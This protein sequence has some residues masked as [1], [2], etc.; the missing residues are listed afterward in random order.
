[1]PRHKVAEKILTKEYLIK[2]YTDDRLTPNQ[3]G[4]IVGCNNSV[5]RRLLKKFG[6][7]IRG[8]SESHKGHTSWNTGLTKETD[9]R[10]AKSAKNNSKAHIGIKYPNRGGNS[11]DYHKDDCSCC[12]CKAARRELVGNKHPHW[13][14]G[15]SSLYE[16]IRNLLEADIW[17]NSVFKRDSYRCQHCY[18]VIK[19]FQAHHAPKPFAT[20]LQEFLQLYSEYSPIEDQEKLFEFA[21]VYTPFWNVDNGKTLCKDCHILMHSSK[22]LQGKKR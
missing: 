1:M 4:K 9:I 3:I 15:T 19:R 22:N 20:L 13:K 18:S 8:I 12:I 16:R 21:K 2:N 6:I 5:V 17:R 7:H 14:G 11:F 10:L